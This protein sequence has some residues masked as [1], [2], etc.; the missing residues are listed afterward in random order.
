MYNFKFKVDTGIEQLG[1]VTSEGHSKSNV[2]TFT[3][4]PFDTQSIFKY[5]ACLKALF[6]GMRNY[7][8]NGFVKASVSKTV[9]GGRKSFEISSDRNGIIS[10]KGDLSFDNISVYENQDGTL[11]ESHYILDK[12]VRGKQYTSVAELIEQYPPQKVAER[13]LKFMGVFNPVLKQYGVRFALDKDNGLC[14]Y[15]DNKPVTID[16]LDYELYTVVQTALSVV[17]AK[18][19]FYVLFVDTSDVEIT[20]NGVLF[21]T[22]GKFFDTLGNQGMVLIFQGN[23]TIGDL[24]KLQR[25]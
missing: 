15:Q 19:E 13:L 6:G 23:E 9:S 3:I 18:G 10:W 12:D 20:N 7:I 11:V 21:T 24:V 1:T 5:K 2:V 22:L 8:P 14:V 25:I 17:S 4:A 16:D